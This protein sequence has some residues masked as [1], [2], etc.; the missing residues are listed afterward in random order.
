MPSKTLNIVYPQLRHLMY[1]LY[2][3]VV[4]R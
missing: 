2:L 1:C 3:Y 4:N